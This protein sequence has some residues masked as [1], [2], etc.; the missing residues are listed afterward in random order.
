ML[1]P[2]VELWLDDLHAEHTVIGLALTNS[3]AASVVAR[4]SR[5]MFRTKRGR[6]VH[7]FVQKEIARGRVPS[8]VRAAEMGVISEDEIPQYDG[9]DLYS[10]YLDSYIL[11][12][13]DKAIIR[14]IAGFNEIYL[15]HGKDVDSA[16]A[17]L[18]RRLRAL[19]QSYATSAVAISALAD[20]V[21]SLYEPADVVT[22]VGWVDDNL[23]IRAGNL[24]VI[25]GRP[26]VG[27]SWF[28]LQ[29][30]RVNAMAGKKVLF[31]T[32]EMSG[33]EVANRLA[34]QAGAK[35]ISQVKEWLSQN[36][37]NIFVSDNARNPDGIR[38]EISRVEG[39]DLVVVDYLQ[40]MRPD[41]SFSG[42]TRNEEVAMVSRSLKGIAM[43]SKIPVI[44]LC[45]LNRAAAGEETKPS[46]HHIRD[47]GAIEADA[48]I[49]I[50]L[51]EQEHLFLD[52]QKNRHG[53]SF[54]IRVSLGLD[55]TIRT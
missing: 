31:V 52:V 43:E 3:G 51:Y 39:V 40:L 17:E 8:P 30:A 14:T 27:K 54:R 19:S 1:S 20:E 32:L 46:L 53:K 35:G 44:A 42:G 25:G 23:A 41:A 36:G 45:Q 24:V 26:A 5:D 55:G 37:A 21:D 11:S 48:D 50:M 38:R 33:A 4:L 7:A 47:S 10:D 13:R 49:V 6:D 12:L 2:E 29:I 34:I 28:G 16:V 15:Q 18:V 9:Y 22:G